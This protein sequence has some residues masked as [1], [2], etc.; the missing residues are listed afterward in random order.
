MCLYTACIIYLLADPSQF[1]FAWIASLVPLII[2]T[3]CQQSPCKY[4]N[5]IWREFIKYSLDGDG[6]KAHRK[7]SVSFV[8]RLNCEVK[9]KIIAIQFT[10][11]WYKKKSEKSRAMQVDNRLIRCA[12]SRNHQ[13]SPVLGGCKLEIHN[14][15]YSQICTCV[16][17]HSVFS[18]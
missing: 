3:K 9:W 2:S 8:F 11:C 15:T 18:L 16:H 4:P 5:W 1:C 17:W 14:A 12:L 10:M 13:P 6:C 7:S